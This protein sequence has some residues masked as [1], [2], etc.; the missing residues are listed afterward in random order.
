MNKGIPVILMLLFVLLVTSLKAQDPHFS[1]FYSNPLLLNPAL[2]GTSNGLYRVSAT[3]RDQWRSALDDPLKTYTV[4][5]DVSFPVSKG[6][7]SLS[8]KFAFG[9][10]FFSDRVSTFDF[11]STQISLFGAYHKALDNA[12]KQYLSA[13]IYLG[14][15]QKNLNYEDLSFED[16]FNAIDGYTLGTGEFLPANN[17]GYGDMGVGVNYTISPSSNSTFYA[18]IAMFHLNSP[19]ISFY[20]SDQTNIELTRENKLFRKW[21]G[22]I[23]ASF[24][25]TEVWSVEPR[26]LFL[27]QGPHKEFNLGSNFKYQLDSDGSKFFHFGPWIRFTDNIDGTNLESFVMAVGFETGKFLLGFSYDHSINDLTSDRL[28]LNA[29]EFTISYFGDYDNDSGYC[30]RF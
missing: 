23:A 4:S 29:F 12:T 11:N 7:R 24:K 18:G 14:I 28:G 20:K 8:D 21:S 22:S 16:Q 19:N 1:Q 6:A 2:T 27:L 9:F 5:G 17:F 15:A 10:N 25:T 3:Y 13:G 26:A 30:P